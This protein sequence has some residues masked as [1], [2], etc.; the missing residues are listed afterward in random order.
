MEE[1]T[2]IREKPRK[3]KDELSDLRDQL[4][5]KAAE[6][7]EHVH[8]EAAMRPHVEKLNNEMDELYRKIDEH[9]SK[10]K[11]YK[12]KIAQENKRHNDAAK[13]N[14]EDETKNLINEIAQ[15][16]QKLQDLLE[17]RAKYISQIPETA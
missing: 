9:E 14:S 11:I 1:G 2:P 8:F 17:E 10:I 15:Y 7:D 6:L 13:M 5:K 3:V 16:E 12:E 4:L